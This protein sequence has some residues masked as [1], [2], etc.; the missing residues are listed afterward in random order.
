MKILKVWQVAKR[1]GCTTRHVAKL[2]DSGKLPGHRLPGSTHR[3]VY[4]DDLE[5]FLKAHKMRTTRSDP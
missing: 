1:L 4:E 3:R 2:V 5:R